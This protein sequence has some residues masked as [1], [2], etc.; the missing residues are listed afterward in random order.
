MSVLSG[1]QRW[2]DQRFSADRC[3]PANHHLAAG[4]LDAAFCEELNRVR[5]DFVLL[6]EDSLSHRL[7]IVIR[8]HRNGGLDNNGPVVHRRIHD[9]YRRAGDCDAVAR[10]LR[11]GVRA[12]ERRQQRW[13]DVQ[14][15]VRV[16]IDQRRRHDAI[17]ARHHDE[18][19]RR[20]RERARHGV[21]KILAGRERPMVDEDSI[22]AARLRSREHRRLWAI[23]DHEPYRRV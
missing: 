22:Q 15:P 5:V 12:G 6:G 18:F 21:V 19:D 4:H 23:A 16:A 13:M 10:G 2:A 1:L 7:G 11:L 14:D 17:E 8:S 3:A 9:V 20:S